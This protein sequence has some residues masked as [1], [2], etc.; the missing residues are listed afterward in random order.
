MSKNIVS[1]IKGGLIATAAMTLLMLIAPMMGLPKMPIGKMLAG[2]MNLPVVVGWAMHFMIGVA[3]AA[4]Y[5]LVLKDRM[6]GRAAV[7]KGIEFSLIP[8]LMAQ[9][10]VM[11]MMG[12]G[13][14]S[15][16]TPAP[17]MM[18]MGSLLGHV[19]YGAVLGVVSK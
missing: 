19:V 9:L 16:N 4:G 12:A 5:I 7:V 10:I 14:F 8:F 13:L 15:T 18:V 6:P 17:M 2:F 11:P 3:L 1:I